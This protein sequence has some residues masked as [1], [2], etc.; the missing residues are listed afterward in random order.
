[1]RITFLGYGNMAKA[2]GGRFK[3][4]HDVVFCGHDAGRAAEAAESVGVSASKDPADAVRGADVVVLATPHDAV[5]DAIESAGGADAFAGKTVVDINNP[6]PGYAEGDFTLH[7]YDDG[8]SLG[9]ALQHR[10][11]DAVVVKAFNTAE[12]KVWQLNPI[13]F[14]GRKFMVLVCGN[15]DQAK[16][17]VIDLIQAMGAQAWDVGGIEYA[18][19]LEAVA[20]LTIQC[21]V[22]GHDPLTVFNLIQPEQQ[23][24]G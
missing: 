17:Q 14:D 21:L 12:A 18:G 6:V 11:P 2:L 15:T 3:N 16:A 10:L 22:D 1:M 9:E 13:E 5:F 24:I 8:P 23:P 4:G 20:A 7:R 19:Q